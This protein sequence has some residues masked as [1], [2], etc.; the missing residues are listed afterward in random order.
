MSFLGSVGAVMKGS[1]LED[2]LPVV[3][4]ENSAMYMLSGKAVS[5]AI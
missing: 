5:R 3:Y 2:L 1:G 4:A